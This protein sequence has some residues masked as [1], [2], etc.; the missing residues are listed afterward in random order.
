MTTT[1]LLTTG[2]V[3]DAIGASRQHVVNLCERGAIRYVRVGKH[4]RIPVEE[5][6]RLTQA[7]S[8]D[9]DALRSLWL[10]RAVLGHL[11]RDPEGVLDRA[12]QVLERRIAKSDY[13]GSPLPYYRRWNEILD[14]GVEEVCRV[15]TD[16]GQE[17]CALRSC[18]PFTGVLSDEERRDVL[19][20]FSGSHA[21]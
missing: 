10:H 7:R 6:E 19:R 12:R 20:A 13:P 5:L 3:A 17:A 1:Q 11:V 18:S 4:R 21:A 16:T 15:L 14:G 9:R 8:L 2:A